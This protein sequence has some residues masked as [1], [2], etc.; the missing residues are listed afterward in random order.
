[1]LEEM[2]Y[3]TTIKTLP[4]LLLEMKKAANLVLQGLKDN[5]IK[6]KWFFP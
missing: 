5:E 2:E 3:K 4:F 1:M 6:E